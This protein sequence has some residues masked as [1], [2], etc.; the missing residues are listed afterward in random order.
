MSFIFVIARKSKCSQMFATVFCLV[1]LNFVNI[2]ILKSLVV[3]STE[4]VSNKNLTEQESIP[5]GCRI[6]DVI[7]SGV[8]VQWGP[9]WR[10]LYSD[11][12]CIMGN[13][14]M[15]LLWTD[16]WT[17]ITGNIMM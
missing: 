5:V 2:S 8:P 13:G 15:G 3:R 14:H 17:D 16:R 4:A 10:G 11:F 9:I 7:R 1:G 6:L 12:Q